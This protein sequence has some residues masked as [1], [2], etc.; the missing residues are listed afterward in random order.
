[1]GDRAAVAE[2]LSLLD[3]DQ[4]RR[5]RRLTALQCL[6]A[7]LDSA[8]V[9]LIGVV[10]VMAAAQAQGTVPPA[11]VP[12]LLDALGLSGRPAGAAIALLAGV[13]VA[14]LVLRSV[15]S[16][17]V[18]RRLNRFLAGCVA[19]V[20]DRTAARFLGQSV[21]DIRQRSTQWTGFALTAG[22]SSV[23]IT[24][25][26]AVAVMWAEVTL[27]VMLCAALLVVDPL[28]TVLAV[29][30]LAIVS[31]T[32]HRFLGRRAA[33]A[34]ASLNEADVRGLTTVTNTI[35]T[36]RELTVADRLD[37]PRATYVAGRGVAGRAWADKVLIQ[38]APRYAADIAL[39]MGAT[40]V[41]GGL[42][43]TTD[44]ETALGT[45]AVFLAAG[46]R[47][48]PSLLRLNGARLSIAAAAGAGEH[49]F[50]LLAELPESSPAAGMGSPV[51][52]RDGQVTQPVGDAVRL[53]GVSFT[54]PG[55]DRP[56]VRDV[57]LR[58]P[59]GESLAV[60]GRSGAGKSTLADLILGMLAPDTGTVLTAGV[61]AGDRS[62]PTR[63]YVPQ[64]AAVIEGTVRDNVALGVPRDEVD[65]DRVWELLTRVRLRDVVTAR[66]GLDSAV[67]EDGVLLSG[68][69]RQRLG[70]ARAL[71]ARPQLIV[72]DE[73]TSALDAETEVAVSEVL[74][75]L[76][77]EVT[78]VIIA[79]RL[80]TVRDSD[81]LVYLDGG[82]VVAAGTFRDVR[83]AVPQFDRQAQ[84]LGL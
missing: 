39:V 69:Q 43:L 2:A 74:R 20:A 62:G 1:M 14:L 83:D 75:S 23:V 7:P 73:A 52:L 18:T 82:T 67:G 16:L 31:L 57:S 42:L 33:A 45:L 63:G 46:T 4:R 71:Y 15:F 77:G 51:P 65:D 35:R 55:A 79:H 13:A 54:Y 3:P 76:A 25:L 81:H 30:Y 60:V 10:A 32:L 6:T 84:L 48:L 5:F 21:L 56:A 22:L 28:L 8:G 44:A 24:L 64:D 9:L 68:G 70:L 58:V 50:A 59:A 34:G 38:Q 26:G 78:R 40:I 47:I 53:N 19:D 17:L 80:S 49:T 61:P 27:L 36:F 12:A 37:V 72:L 29:G 11:P 66:G 41:V